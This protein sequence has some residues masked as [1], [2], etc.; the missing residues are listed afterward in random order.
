MH[1]EIELHTL[2]KIACVQKWSTAINFEVSVTADHPYVLHTLT[3]ASKPNAAYPILAGSSE[4]HIQQAHIG[5]NVC[6]IVCRTIRRQYDLCFLH[7][8]IA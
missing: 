4:F 3:L 8:G 5:R 2:A 7:E 6:R 1:S